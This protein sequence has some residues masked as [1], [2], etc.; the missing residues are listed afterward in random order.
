MARHFNAMARRP[1]RG[2]TWLL[3]AAAAAP[4]CAQ[5]G[6]SDGDERSTLIG[7][8]TERQAEKGRAVFL[9]HCTEC[10]APAAV[11]GPPFRRNWDGRSALDFFDQIRTTMPNDDPGRLSRGQYTEIV[12]YVFKYHGFP[13]G[14]R[15]LPSDESGLRRIRIEFPPPPQPPPA[16]PRQ[17]RVG[18]ER[19]TG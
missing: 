12:A 2:G 18:P 4:L 17:G 9:K 6:S 13:A 15:P 14:Q 10:H 7:A 19:P 11:I 1:F 8:Y 16:L 5:E 3:V